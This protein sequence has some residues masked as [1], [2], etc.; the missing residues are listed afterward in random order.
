[1]KQ[2]KVHHVG[3]SWWFTFH[4]QRGGLSYVGN[5]I[6][7]VGLEST[8][9]LPRSIRSAVRWWRHTCP[10]SWAPVLLFE[11]VFIY[12]LMYALSYA[13]IVRFYLF[14]NFSTLAFMSSFHF[15]EVNFLFIFKS[16]LHQRSRATAVF[17]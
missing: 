7:C 8:A 5:D 12:N 17:Y 16:H 13:L 3:K 1:M 14:L 9:R 6:L 2:R 10:A 4:K 15:R 11:P